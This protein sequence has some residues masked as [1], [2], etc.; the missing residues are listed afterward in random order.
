MVLIN[1]VTLVCDR[2]DYFVDK[3]S[4]LYRYAGVAKGFVY[5]E[6]IL[7]KGSIREIYGLLAAM[8]H[9]VVHVYVRV[10]L[11]VKILFVLLL[12]HRPKLVIISMPVPTRL[13]KLQAYLLSLLVG[14]NVSFSRNIVFA[15]ISP[16]DNY[17]FSRY[18]GRYKYIYIPFIMYDR[19]YRVPL[20]LVSSEPLVILYPVYHGVSK[21][22]LEAIDSLKR[23]G[24]SPKLILVGDKCISR[25]HTLCI[26]C[27]EY[28][29]YIRNVSL[30]IVLDESIESNTILADLVAAGKPVVTLEENPY[31]Y[32]FI[33]TGFIVY[34]TRIDT[35]LLISAIIDIIN[36]IDAYKKIF[37]NYRLE[38]P[39][40]RDTALYLYQKIIEAIKR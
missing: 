19:E 7:S 36:N 24:L 8:E 29:D 31:S 30:G 27:E 39:S 12:V 11:L 28:S 37:V 34:I 5:R 25:P 1:T 14:L 35:E 13:E 4:R 2:R 21:C 22:V 15:Y 33:N 16:Y 6:F 40:V 18:F 3:I 32:Q 10:S 23:H 38:T 26:L 17:R 9:D 20:E